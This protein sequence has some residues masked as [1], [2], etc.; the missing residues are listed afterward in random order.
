M[1]LSGAPGRFDLGRVVS[2]V[3]GV[4]SRN[5]V[6]FGLLSLMLVG[7]PTALLSIAQLY[8][9]APYTGSPAELVQNLLTPARIATSA[10][11][12]LVTFA[13][14]AVLQGAIMHGTVNDLSGES[15]PFGD[16]L[17]TGLRFLPQ[18]VGVAIV[19]AIGTFFGYLLLIVPGVILALAWSVAA[20]A[21]VAE[22]RG[23]FDAL[24]RSL[25]LTRNHRLAIF[26][27]AIVLGVIG[28]LLSIAGNLAFRAAGGA[29]ALMAFRTGS[30][31]MTTIFVEQAV[32]SLVETTITSTISAAGVASL[33]FELRQAK[34]GLGAEQLAATFD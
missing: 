32:L 22:R 29:N 20:P 19:A 27:L 1:S 2:R 3:A 7:V 5:Y 24:S 9:S 13:C 26:G 23:V 30:P 28:F 21:V 11:A 12:A 31:R 25:D 8:L 18:L 6:V 10:G 14:G 4:L 34:E 16:L 33:Y 15:V 17:A